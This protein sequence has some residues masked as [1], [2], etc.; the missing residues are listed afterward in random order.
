LRIGITSPENIPAEWKNELYTLTRQRYGKKFLLPIY[1]LKN[2]IAKDSSKIILFKSIRANNNEC[3]I[4]KN[5]RLRMIV[6]LIKNMIIGLGVPQIAEYF[7]EKNKSDIFKRFL[8]LLSRI[9]AAVCLLIRSQCY[10]IV[11]GTNTEHNAQEIKKFLI[12]QSKH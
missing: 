3:I 2:Q 1:A 7:F 6:P 4:K 5:S 12:S 10:I 9:M 11:L 8:I